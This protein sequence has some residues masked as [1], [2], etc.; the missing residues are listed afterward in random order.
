MGGSSNRFIL[1][2]TWLSLCRTGI[3][4]IDADHRD[5]H[6]RIERLH[7]ACALGRID[8]CR[9][10]SAGLLVA[11]G[12]HF[13]R[14]EALFAPTEYPNARHHAD[15]HRQLLHRLT[16]FATAVAHGSPSI[17]EIADGADLVASVLMTDHVALDMDLKAYLQAGD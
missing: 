15:Q 11:I 10:V 2:T 13:H 8:Q 7:E 12:R 5:I 9:T 6:D 14:E 3:G 4:S 16:V 17:R 1:D